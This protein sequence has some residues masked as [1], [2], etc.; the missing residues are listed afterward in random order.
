MLC[1]PAQLTEGTAQRAHRAFVV[2]LL[3]IHTVRQV[4]PVARELFTGDSLASTCLRTLE[5]D[6]KLFG[7]LVELKKN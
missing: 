2:F 3:T 4:A 5:C 7:F 6:L 1:Q